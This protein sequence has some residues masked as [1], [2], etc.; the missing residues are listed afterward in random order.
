MM[1]IGPAIDKILS[2]GLRALRR[3]ALYSGTPETRE[4]AV[5]ALC[6]WIKDQHRELNGGELEW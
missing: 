2:L 1:K 4:Q 5:D 6:E 3:D